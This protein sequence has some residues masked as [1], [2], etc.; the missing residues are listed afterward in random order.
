MELLSN[1]KLTKIHQNQRGIELKIG[2]LTNFVI[3]QV[4]RSQGKSGEVL[5]GQV[6]TDARLKDKL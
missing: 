2:A 6:G 5:S 1:P 4:G 3:T